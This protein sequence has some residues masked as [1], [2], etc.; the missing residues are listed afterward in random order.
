M[1]N[2]IIYIDALKGLAIILVVWG[3]IAEKSMGIENTS[4]NWMYSSFHMPLFIFLSGLFAYKD[5]K[6]PSWNYIWLFLKKKA[7]RILLPFLIVGSFYSLIV[8]H[9]LTSVLRG[10]FG[11]YWFLPALFYCMILG[12]LQRCLTIICGDVKFKEIFAFLLVW[13]CSA[14]IWKINVPIPY[15]LP[16]LKMYPYFMAGHYCRQYHFLTNGY[17]NI[18]WVQTIA[19]IMYVLTL[20][21]TINTNF[22]FISLTGIFAIILLLDFFAGHAEKIPTWLSVIGSYSLEIY[23]L[24]WF[25]LPKMQDFGRYLLKFGSFNENFILVTA[26]CSVVGFFIITISWVVAKFIKQSDILDYLC[27]GV[28]KKN[29]K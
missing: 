5:M 22:H 10:E 18:Q 20:F 16:A 17:L 27:F 28:K 3:H 9:S 24:H 13:G 21:F 15:W 26:V 8:E 4:F 23:V 12:L 25:F 11:G 14:I 7:V 6:Q 19:I 1:N 29:I 2:R